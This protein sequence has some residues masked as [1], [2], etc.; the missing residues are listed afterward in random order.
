MTKAVQRLEV[1]QRDTDSALK[2]SIQIARETG[3]DNPRWMDALK[4]ALLV[5]DFFMSQAVSPDGKI[6]IPKLWR[7]SFYIEARKL[8]ISIKNILNEH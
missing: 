2:Q 5:L 6:I 3:V 1:V 7:I 4:I 8:F